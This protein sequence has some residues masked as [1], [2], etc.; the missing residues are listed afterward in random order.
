[1]NPYRSHF[2]ALGFFLALTVV[3]SW[4]LAT[5]LGH[6]LPVAANPWL[7]ADIDLLV[8][9]LAWTS[10]AII[11]A[12]LEIFEATVFHPAPLALTASENLIGLTPIST[13]ALLAS[14]NP[15]FT[16]NFTLLSVT[17]LTAFTAYWAV[18]EYEDSLLAGLL[19]GSLL[20]FDP[21][22]IHQWARLHESAVSLFPLVFLLAFRVARKP[23][24]ANFCGLIL[25]TSI[26][27]LAG[28][29]LAFILGTFAAGLAPGLI[30][31]AR[32]AG[33]TGLRPLAA[34]LLGTLAPAVISIP[35]I[36]RQSGGTYPELQQALE[37]ANLYSSPLGQSLAALSSGTGLL[38]AP[39]G[40]LGL[41]NRR[42]PTA[43]RLSLLL[44]LCLGL[45]IAAG[46]GAALL[47]GTEI[48]GIYRGLANIL[49]GFA[50]MRAPARFL[51]ISH[52]SLAL[53]AGFGGA[54]LLRVVV[55][56]TGAI[57]S[58]IAGGALLAIT[59]T[60][61]LT[62]Q[63]LWPMS[64]TK[65]P[66]GPFFV[67]AYQWLAGH[68]TE[69]AVL[70]LPAMQTPLEKKPLGQTGRAMRGSLEHGLALI[71]GYSGHPPPSHALLM[72]WAQRLPQS[73]ALEDFCQY[74]DLRWIIVHNGLLQGSEKVLQAGLNRWGL[75]ERARF[76]RD[77]IYEMPHACGRD[78]QV[79]REHTLSREPTTL[80]GTPMRELEPDEK[81]GTISA[82][83]TSPWLANSI[84]HIDLTI[85]NDSKTTWPGRT[86]DRDHA[87]SINSRWVSAAGVVNP[88]CSLPMLLGR[89]LRPGEVLRT[90]F[91]VYAPNE[92]A[93]WTLEIG[94]M[95]RGSGWFRDTGGTASL[96]Y[97]LRLVAPG[98]PVS[99]ETVDAAATALPQES[100]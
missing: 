16:Y 78:I 13:P 34:L 6:T 82:N 93:D 29:Y 44:S 50:T 9:I 89:D 90:P 77:V 45:L 37:I 96:S 23:S 24:I 10:R 39:L 1:M 67:G 86:T 11:T 60:L 41:F 7:R 36:T 70:E 95:Q 52:I 62:S 31:Q 94:L 57:A 33:Q 79:L 55:R 64:T 65:V 5:D 72:T 80:A 8:W 27:I 100:P 56:R 63:A 66:R 30:W 17:F 20:A 71:N 99:T 2:S 35:Y 38:A 61:I 18:R 68:A 85:R 88:C 51:V 40:I 49:P 83:L 74:T 26:Q 15:I 3:V 75:R 84:H 58:R 92:P 42:V 32:R 46:P 43:I 47:P 14:G 48:P 97:P 4:P 54:L 91:L 87:V 25:V 28:V 19:A 73:S 81:T 69:G 53:L 76:G 21:H 98:A 59:L 12:P 22:L